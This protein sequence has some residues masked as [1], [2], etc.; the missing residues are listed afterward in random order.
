MKLTTEEH[1]IVQ[2]VNTYFRSPKMSLR[3]K[4]F[5]AKLITLHDLE[6]QQFASE[7]EREKLAHYNL[8]LDSILEKLDA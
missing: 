2:R 4:V 5:N 1:R 6:L 8:I 3:E 7:S